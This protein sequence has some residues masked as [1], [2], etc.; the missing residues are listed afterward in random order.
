MKGRTELIIWDAALML[1]VLLFIFWSVSD[2]YHLIIGIL[3]VMVFS[4]AVQKHI[5]AYKLNGKIY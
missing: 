3:S 1:G 4:F 5:A 2:N